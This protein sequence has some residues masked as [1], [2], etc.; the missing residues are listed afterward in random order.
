[1]IKVYH[2]KLQI[3]YWFLL[4]YTSSHNILNYQQIQNVLFTFFLNYIGFS[5]ITKPNNFDYRMIFAE[6]CK[7]NMNWFSIYFLLTFFFQQ[8]LLW[9]ILIESLFWGVY[10]FL[11]WFFFLGFFRGGVLFCFFMVSVTGDIH[12]SWFL[13]F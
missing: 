11:F 4:I 2:G 7:Q 9:I 12:Y 5:F 1:M 3:F 8:M 10:L 13:F 6:L